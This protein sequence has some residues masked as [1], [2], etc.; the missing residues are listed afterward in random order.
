[1]PLSVPQCLREPHTK[2]PRPDVRSAEAESPWTEVA[3]PLLSVRGAGG[4]PGGV[5][6]LSGGPAPAMGPVGEPA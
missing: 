4:G 6:R 3:R 1:M 2:Q 5:S